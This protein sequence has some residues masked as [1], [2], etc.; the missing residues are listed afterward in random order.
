MD[1]ADP[2]EPEGVSDALA[3]FTGPGSAKSAIHRCATTTCESD[4]R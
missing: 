2:N 4:Q 3:H 1:W